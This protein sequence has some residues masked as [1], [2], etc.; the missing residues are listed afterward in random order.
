[1]RTLTPA[2]GEIWG[3]VPLSFQPMIEVESRGNG[4]RA[5]W[6]LDTSA[7]AAAT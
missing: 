5:W 3:K 2:V 1:M 4:H 7:P 6:P